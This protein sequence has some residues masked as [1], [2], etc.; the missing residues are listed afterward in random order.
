MHLAL[1]DTGKFYRYEAYLVFHALLL[2]GVIVYQS[3]PVLR[4]QFLLWHRLALLVAFVFCLVPLVLRSFAGFSKAHRACINI[5][6]QQFQM[7]RFLQAN[8]DIKVAAANDIGAV[9]YYSNSYI[10]DLWGLG[11]IETARSKKNGY[12][13]AAYLSQLATQKQT[14][15]VMIYDSWIDKS[16][17][18]EWVKVGEWQIFNNVV[19]GDDFVSFYALNAAEVPGLLKRLHSFEKALPATVAVHYEKRVAQ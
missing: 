19:C 7:A 10:L 1:A 8:P 11:N 3:W 6:E 18:S 2:T 14:N 16:I 9:A 4:H 15:A 13:N 5:Y 12:W 17:P